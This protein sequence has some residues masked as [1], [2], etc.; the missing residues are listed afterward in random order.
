LSALLLENRTFRSVEP[1]V[2]SVLADNESGNE[3][4]TQ[5]GFIYDLVACNP[6]YKKA[7][8]GY[9]VKMFPKIATD[10][11]QST[12]HGIVLDLGCGSNKQ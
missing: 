6:I 10:A 5:L 4:D 1:S 7:I 3:Y 11:L 2:Y 8:G 12:P 9:S